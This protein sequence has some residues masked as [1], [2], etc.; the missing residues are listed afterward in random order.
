MVQK[1]F[2]HINTYNSGTPQCFTEFKSNDTLLAD[3]CPGTKMLLIYQYDSVKQIPCRTI[4]SAISKVVK[5]HKK[6]LF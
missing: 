5:F 2:F 3:F 1:N 4:T 6:K